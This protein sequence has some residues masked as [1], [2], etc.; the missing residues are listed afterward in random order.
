VTRTLVLSLL[1]GL[2]AAA[3]TPR[4]AQLEDLTA[5]GNGCVA[6]SRSFSDEARKQALALLAS[7]EAKAGSLGD[8]ELLVANDAI[9]QV[10]GMPPD[11]LLPRR[12]SPVRA[13]SPAP[14]ALESDHGW[15]AALAPDR[16]PAYQRDADAPFRSEKLPALDALYVQF[17][18][19]FDE[20]AAASR[21]L[22]TSS[23]PRS[24]RA[25]RATRSST[26]AS[27]PAATSI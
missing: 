6:K 8:A 11:E 9:T 16:A 20:G 14:T 19:N 2:P 10:E 15:R 27:T 7:L 12:L 13:W 1:T 25:R 4:E 5:A 26:C 18:A 17:R 3:K 23:P 24:R 21:A 22:P